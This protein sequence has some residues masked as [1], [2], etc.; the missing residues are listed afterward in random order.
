MKIEKGIRYPIRNGVVDY[1]KFEIRVTVN[2]KLRSKVIDRSLGIKEARRVRSEMF[3]EFNKSTYIDPTKISLTDLVN[4]YINTKKNISTID[5]YTN[6]YQPIKKTFL[7]DMRIDKITS[8]H[9]D[10]VMNKFESQGYKNNYRNN[11]FAVLSASML[12]A[13]RMSLIPHESPT[14]KVKSPTATVRE[15]TLWS[16]AEF[17]SFIAEAK[18]SVSHF[19]Q[20]NLNQEYTHLFIR[21][22]DFLQSVGCRID[23]ALGLTW[24]NYDRANKKLSFTKTVKVIKNMTFPV[25]E[26]TKRPKHQRSIPLTPRAISILDELYENRVV[27]DFENP[28][29]FNI[30]GKP[31]YPYSLSRVFKKLVLK[32]EMP[33]PFAM[34]DTRKVFITEA[35]NRGV[36]VQDVADYVGNTPE[37]IWRTYAR[38]TESSQL[39]LVKKMGSNG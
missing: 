24:D 26:G 14:R 22:Y 39:E 10:Q 29:I 11:I 25:V 2:A 21:F 20:S 31:Y 15:V 32:F 13:E 33:Q 12:Y 36:P 37:Q 28:Y 38:S 4:L 23:E 17:D 7:G 5:R 6:D 18:E 19:Y 9:I 35:L 34:K 30:K 8:F 1:S 16:Q 3:T 27:I